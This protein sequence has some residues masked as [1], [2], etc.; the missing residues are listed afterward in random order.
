MSCQLVY[1][2]KSPRNNHSALSPCLHSI[3]YTTQKKESCQYHN[4]HDTTTVSWQVFT[5]YNLHNLTKVYC[6]LVNIPQI[7]RHKQIVLSLFISY[8]LQDA[9]T[10]N[11]HIIYILHPPR[12]NNWTLN[13]FIY[14]NRQ[15]KTTV[16][17]YLFLY[18][19]T[20]TTQ[21][22]SS[23]LVYVPKFPRQNHSTMSRFYILQHPRTK[24]NVL[25]P[26][27]YN[28]VSITQPQCPVTLIKY[29]NF[30]EKPNYSVHFFINCNFQVPTKSF[31]SP[32][33]YTYTSM[34]KTYC[35][36]SLFI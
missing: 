30:H 21:K 16:S 12:I 8:N 28:I 31:L 22:K 7:P 27:L 18:T 26:P 23:H 36:V 35:P 24:H 33:I 32:R 5:Y 11:F 1:I 17:C 13:S 9:T 19:T 20:F 14:H 15:E 25:S 6:H 4:L 10:L 2:L 3:T 29:Y 34:I